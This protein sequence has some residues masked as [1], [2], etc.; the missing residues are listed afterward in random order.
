MITVSIFLAVFMLEPGWSGPL[1]TPPPPPPMVLVLYAVPSDRD[2]SPDYADAVRVAILHLQG[3]YARQLDGPTFAIK[4]PVPLVC[5]VDHQAQYFE[6]VHGWNRVL[7]SVQHCA[8][9]RHS[10][11]R[12]TWAIYIDVEFDCDGG[13]ELGAGGSGI[14]IVHGGDLAGLADPENYQ[15]CGFPPHRGLGWVGGL[16]HEISHAFGLPHPPGCEEE[17]D[18]CDHN[19]MMWAGFYDYPETYLRDDEKAALRESVF[20]H[21]E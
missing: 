7:D 2:Y 21:E 14:T 20:F 19:A 4:D 18:T 16:A 12:Y 13:G 8:P 17:L 9:V 11:D 6:R 10:S 1:P 5:T 15:L 3:W